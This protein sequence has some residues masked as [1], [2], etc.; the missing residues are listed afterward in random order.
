MSFYPLLS[1][2]RMSPMKKMVQMETFGLEVWI[3]QQYQKFG[4]LKDS[5]DSSSHLKKK[6]NF[7]RTCS[8][9]SRA[10]VVFVVGLLPEEVLLMTEILHHLG[11]TKP[12][13]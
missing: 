12:S 1:S 10:I 11:C 4:W 5:F 8:F 2:T 9:S 7:K 13:K 3:M 6:T